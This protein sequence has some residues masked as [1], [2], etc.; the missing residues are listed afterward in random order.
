MSEC[1]IYERETVIIISNILS[2]T[3]A[4]WQMEQNIIR[5]IAVN[6][7]IKQST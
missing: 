4:K 1:W 2:F 5:N 6:T 3:A 7:F